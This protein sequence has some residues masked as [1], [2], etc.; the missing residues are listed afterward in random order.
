M[1]ENSLKDEITVVKR[2]F[3]SEIYMKWTTEQQQ[4]IDIRDCNVL[5]SAAAG[6]GKTAV[7]TERIRKLIMDDAVSIE[8]MLIVTFSNAAASEMKEKIIKALKKAAYADEDKDIP[9][10]KTEF[11]RRQISIAHNADISTFHSF[12]MNVIRKYFYKAG[13]EPGFAI[14]DEA[15]RSIIID[16]VL[17]NLIESRFENDAEEF[18]EFMKNY[19]S[20]KNDKGVRSLI[21]YV[22]GFIMSLPDPFEWLDNAVSN[23]E[24]DEDEFE[25][26]FI[27]KALELDVK[28]DVLKALSLAENVADECSHLESLHEKAE[29]DLEQVKKIYEADT[30]PALSEAFKTLNF[31]T[32]RAKKEE[33][34]EYEYIKTG[35]TTKR[36][37]MKAILGEAEQKIVLV[38]PKEAANRIASTHKSAEY[39]TGLIK[40]FHEKFKAD[41][42][43]RNLL[44]FNDLEHIALEILKDDDIAAEYHKR[45][46]VIFVDEYQDSSVIQETLISRVSR[47]NNVFMVGDV[48]QSIYKFRQAEPE[49]F[50]DKYNK[51]C[52]G[53]GGRRIDLNRNFRSKRYIIDS[54]NSIFLHI[55]NRKSCGI[56]YDDAATLK[57]GVAYEGEF[58]RKTS[59]HLIDKTVSDEFA[60]DTDE[61]VSLKDAELEAV[62]IAELVSKKI[63]QKIYDSKND[64]IR[65]VKPEDIVILL[66]SAKNR[67]DIFARALADIGISTLVDAGDSYFETNEIEVF[68]NLLSVI[69]NKKNDIPLIS[70]LRSSIFNFSIDELVEIRLLNKDVEYNEAFKLYADR[71]D[72]IEQFD[73]EALQNTDFDF[74]LAS[75]CADV[76]KRL[77]KWKFNARFMNLEDFLHRLISETGYMNYILALPGG[78]GRAANLR[79]LIDKAISFSASQNGGLYEFLSYIDA[80][81]RSHA[82]IPQA[83]VADDPENTVRIMT[84]HKSKGLEFPIV[85]VAGLNSAFNRDKNS[86]HAVMNRHIGLGLSYI[87]KKLHI[88]AQTALQS[89]IKMQNKKDARAEEMRVYYVALTRAMDEL[90]LVG[91]LKNAQQYM[92]NAESGF[93]ADYDTAK[94]FLDWTAPYCREAEIEVNICMREDMIAEKKIEENRREKLFKNIE[95]GFPEYKDEKNF[96]SELTSRF[97]FKYPYSSDIGTK[98]KFTVSELNKLLVKDSKETDFKD[99][100]S[101]QL[102]EF[103]RKD[104]RVSAVARGTAVH[105]VMQLI[106]FSEDNDVEF[107]SNFVND[108]VKSHILTEK[109]AAAVPSDKIAAFFKS[110]TGKQAC[111]AKLLKRE[112][113]FTLVKSGKEISAMTEDSELKEEIKKSLPSEILIQGVIDCFFDSGDGIVI[114]DY[115]TDHINPDYK[116]REFKRM[117]ENYSRQLELYRDVVENSTGKN[118]KE[119]VLFLIDTAD[120][121]SI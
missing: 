53:D 120:V 55:M 121:L 74:K 15:R 47:G 48:K 67:A 26:S 70:V 34:E 32:F 3:L 9:Y 83:V 72:E 80:V 58:D 10:D 115:K 116:D 57:K 12:A 110:E 61:L 14:C 106:P 31:A 44:D 50:I 2:I 82:K 16:D 63:G 101:E 1:A 119:T 24:I 36:D 114:I 85:I 19:S 28:N 41:K 105:R 108:L 23:L 5:V 89:L 35:I 118:V 104:E 96:L 91:S 66:R 25:K 18:S 17:D 77:E 98:S 117:R 33:K 52:N 6:S 97:S 79:L 29:S 81:G 93:I 78:D 87:D 90:I 69:D 30:F 7:L 60:D 86:S 4:A 8:N 39:L 56:D 27:Y 73:E 94:S 99:P 75:K 20:V 49:I 37:L 113:P 64:S 109:E 92:D 103:L 21:L 65:V 59:L 13:V 111:N 76:M 88:H 11:L 100:I 40:E 42:L 22:Y 45:F 68:I 54:I 95:R 46:D 84:I 71:F 107:V 51:F 102:P 112:W 62:Y 43:E 38:P